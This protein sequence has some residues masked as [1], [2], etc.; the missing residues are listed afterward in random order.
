MKATIRPLAPDDYPEFFAYLNAQLEENGKNGN[1]LFQPLSREV[2]KF[3]PDK[4]SSFVAGLSK[5][6]GQAGWRRAWVICNKAGQ[7][8]GHIDLRAHSDSGIIHRALLGMGVGLDYRRLGLGRQLLDFA[9]DWVKNHDLLDWI[10]IEVLSVN[11]PA[12]SLY[13]NAGFDFICEMPDLF[14]IDERPET[15]IRMTRKIS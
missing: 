14:R 1:P 9:C 3:P 8:M 13:E 15:V 2:L 10:D 4:E 5:A 6:V 7:I 11:K 12:V